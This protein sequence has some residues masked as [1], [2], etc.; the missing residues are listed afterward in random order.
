MTPRAMLIETIF[1]GHPGNY[2]KRVDRC[3]RLAYQIEADVAYG[4]NTQSCSVTLA[5][6]TYYEA[7][8]LRKTESL[9]RWL[10]RKN[11]I[12]TNRTPQIKTRRCE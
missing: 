9:L 1:A 4:I 2:R 8:G 7:D 11:R 6:G 5:D 12:A 10:K 3:D